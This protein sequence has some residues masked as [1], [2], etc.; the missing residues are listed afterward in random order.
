MSGL[1]G[2]PVFRV[3]DGQY[4]WEDVLLSA[5]LRDEWESVVA[6]VRESLAC[7]R[8]WQQSGRALPQA[9]VDAAAAEFRYARDLVSAADMHAWLDSWGLSVGAWMGYVRR[10]LARERAAAEGDPAELAAALQPDDDAV[11]AALVPAL[12]CSGALARFA[13]ALAADAAVAERAEAMDGD[14]AAIDEMLARVP[15][16]L[17]AALVAPLDAAERQE[18]LR[19][20]AGLAVAR[21][22]FRDAVLTPKMLRRELE[23]RQLDWIHVDYRTAAFPT[24]GMAREAVLCVRDDGLDLSTVA[25]EAGVKIASTG[26]W[27][28]EVD[29]QLRDQLLA[30]RA[31]DVVGPV[32]VGDAYVIHQVDAKRLPTLDD[33]DVRARIEASALAR[34]LG[35]AESDRVVWLVRP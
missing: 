20:V 16:A 6:D 11:H 3:A 23:G 14:A 2:R 29:R 18:R 35:G 5:T 24:D 8:W 26:A 22:R 34:A 33:P 21:R 4:F 28:G 10:T 25:H 32:G 7:L 9:D 30:A 17:L 19:V 27:L 31:G 13:H 15:E 1:V 12:V